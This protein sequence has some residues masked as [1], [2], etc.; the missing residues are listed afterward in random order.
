MKICL[1]GD[2][3]I[4]VRNDSPLFHTIFAKFYTDF[5]FPYL[6]QHGILDIVQLGDVF[7]RRKYIN[8]N[9]L[10][11]SKQYLFDPLNQDFSTYML[12]GNHDTYYKNT[13]KVNSLE[14]L[15][16]EYHQIHVV[17]EPTVVDFEG[18]KFLLVPWIS[19]DN[20]D[21]VLNAIK[22][23]HA[24]VIAGH[25]EISGFEMYKGSVCEHGMER[26]LFSGCETVVSGHFH[27]QSKVGNI[28]YIGTPYEMTW[29][30]YNDPKGFHVYDT[31][32]REMTFVQS[33]YSV[34]HKVHYD[35]AGKD[36]NDV[37]SVDFTPYRDTFV[38]VIVGEKTNPYTFDKFIDKLEKAGVFDIQVVDD[39]HHMGDQSDDVI[40][41]EAQDTL[42]LLTSYVEQVDHGVPSSRL[43]GL[44][45]ELYSEALSVE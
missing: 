34:F 3:H 35:D 37:L 38:K 29:S 41:G 30:D 16:S 23:Q 42:S 4:G 19:D 21:V 44:M 5:F 32:T 1:L 20:A 10:Y 22:T 36:V 14:L 12:V 11:E 40:M 18:V 39:H 26:A 2:T 7:D 33:P 28:H 17:N 6:R 24:D 43:T 9:S 27:H 45:T 15:L 25:F 13:N 8:F 31:D